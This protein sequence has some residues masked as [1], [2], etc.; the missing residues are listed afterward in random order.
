MILRFSIVAVL[1]SVALA[2]FGEEAVEGPV[3]HQTTEDEI[4]SD[5]MRRGELAALEKDLLSRG[6]TMNEEGIRDFLQCLTGSSPDPSAAKLVAQLGSE[7]FA[8]RENAERSLKKLSVAPTDLLQTVA[9]GADL[10]AAIRAKAVLEQAIP[11]QRQTVVKV[12]RAME[13]L[14]LNLTGEVF[15]VAAK[16]REDERVIRAAK[17]AMLAAVSDD[18]IPL[19][20]S[21][22][23]PEATGTQREFSIG[24]LRNLENPK[25]AQEFAIWSKAPRF[26]ETTRL[27]STLALAD[28]GDRRSLELLVNLMATADS[29][30]VRSG[31]EVALRK[32]TGQKFELSANAEPGV[33]AEK[34]RNWSDWVARE[35]KTAKLHFP[36]RSLRS[37]YFGGLT[38]IA[39]PDR[40]RVVAFDA[41]MNEVWWH[42]CSYPTSAEKMENGNLLIAAMLGNRVFEVTPE[43][44]IIRE[45]I[46]DSPSAARPLA[47]GNFLIAAKNRVLEITP[48]GRT[49]WSY[50]GLLLESPVRLEGGNTLTGEEGSVFEINA[51]GEKIWEFKID[52]SKWH[53]KSIDHIQA[54]ENG[55]VLISILVAAVIE[56][57]KKTNEI[58]WRF[59]QKGIRDAYRLPDGNTLILT[60]ERV[61]EIDRDGKELWSKEHARRASSGGTI[62]R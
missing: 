30:L 3:S 34:M 11:R 33:R 29:P 15:Q 47:N 61:F 31:C 25:L 59:D 39:L 13:L 44:E 32:L 58:V 53:T 17:K 56:V 40:N 38:V 5:E 22:M 62:R 8:E 6:V 20:V 18:D 27:R 36:L 21:Q 48:E 12:L 28:L 60:E 42:P 26:T 49:V 35:G 45:H 10:E 9:G 46:V 24:A 7:S 51:K 23:T 52:S 57:D 37:D 14:N 1:G 2:C 4:R 16:F 55:N 50:D 43:G 54:L 41:V 19:L